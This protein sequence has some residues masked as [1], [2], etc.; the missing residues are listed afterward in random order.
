MDASMAAPAKAVPVRFLHPGL[1]K[2]VWVLQDNGDAKVFPNWSW[3]PPP[4]P[5]EADVEADQVIAGLGINFGASEVVE[6]Q[7]P[8]YPDCSTHFVNRKKTGW[9]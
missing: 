4:F 5:Q 8:D 3:K 6:N 2:F 1:S 9:W 7:V